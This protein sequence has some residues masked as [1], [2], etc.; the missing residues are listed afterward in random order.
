V[1]E[2][3]GHVDTLLFVLNKADRIA[4]DQRD[5]AMGFTRRVLEQTLG[6]GVDRIY[7]VSALAQDDGP[8]AAH[9][10]NALV[11]A[12]HRLPQTSGARLVASAVERGRRR[13]CRELRAL[14]EAERRALLAPLAESSRQLTALAELASRAARARRELEPQLLVEERDLAREFERRRIEFLT[15]TLPRAHADLRER[16]DARVRRTAA[17][18][19]AND[20]AR[21]RI[22]PWLQASE[23]D[24]DRAYGGAMARFGALAQALLGRISGAMGGDSDA[25]RLDAALWGGLQAPRGFYFTDRLSGHYSPLPWAGLA[26]WLTPRVISGRRRLRAAERYLEDLLM[27]NATRVESDLRDRVGEG[28]RRLEAELDRLLRD[29]GQAATRAAERGHAAQAAGVEAVRHECERLNQWLSA[30]AEL[31]RGS[32][33]EPSAS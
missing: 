2:L 10:W 20:I 28:R 1:A 5:E 30:L 21:A 6:H 18:E 31:E 15:L 13:L 14:L 8:P 19:L 29:V 26:D 27:V 16:F 32:G 24:A 22:T 17:L 33:P 4:P 25:L 3:A 12:L 7:E 23:R 11:A 9:G